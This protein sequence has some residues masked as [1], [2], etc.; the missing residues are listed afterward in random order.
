[1]IFFTNELQGMPPQ[2]EVDHAIELVRGVTPIARA[3]YR[4]FFEENVELEVN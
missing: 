3:P 4:H 1:M 2:R